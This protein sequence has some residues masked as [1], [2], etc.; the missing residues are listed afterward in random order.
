MILIV[1]EEI[2]RSIDISPS[3]CQHDQNTETNCYYITVSLTA[4]L[5]H[6]MLLYIHVGSGSHTNVRYHTLHIW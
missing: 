4:L 2:M 6:V 3:R 5:C 1:K